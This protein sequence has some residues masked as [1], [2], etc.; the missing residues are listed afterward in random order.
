LFSTE[1]ETDV[2]AVGDKATPDGTFDL[3]D[4]RTVVIANG[5]ITEIVEVDIED[6]R[7]QIADLTAQL[8]AANTMNEEATTLLNEAQTEIETLAKIRSTAQIPQRTGASGSAGKRT[9]ALSEEEKKAAVKAA[10]K[11]GGKK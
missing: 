4:G 6:L 1:N 10:L 5:I 8:E 9:T 3:P 7:N 2:I 11:N